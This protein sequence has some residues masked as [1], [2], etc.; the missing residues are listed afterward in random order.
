MIDTNNE[1]IEKAQDEFIALVMSWVDTEE[2]FKTAIENN[3]TPLCR[4][5]TTSCVNSMLKSYD[6]WYKKWLEDGNKQISREAVEKLRDKYKNMFW[7]T[8]WVLDV[9][10]DLDA[11][12]DN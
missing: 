10:K 9:A 7:P 12:L 5:H 8:I 4:I 1:W 6:G 2:S 3:L 11:L